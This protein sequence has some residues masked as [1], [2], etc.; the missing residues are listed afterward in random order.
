M[1]RELSETQKQ[2]AAI[3]RSWENDPEKSGHFTALLRQGGRLTEDAARVN[4]ELYT[5]ESEPISPL[6][7]TLTLIAENDTFAQR[8]IDLQAHGINSGV[9]SDLRETGGHQ[10]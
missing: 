5:G 10:R 1:N 6:T 2:A 3:A 9:I 7:T 4:L 8:V